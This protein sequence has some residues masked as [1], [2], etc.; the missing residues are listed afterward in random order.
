MSARRLRL[1]TLVALCV[2]FGGLSLWDTAAH[3][4]LAHNY[5]SKITE[6]PAKGPHGEAISLSGPLFET[7]GM[8]VDAGHL[9]TS[10]R[11]GAPS[12]SA[13][14]LDEWE[15]SSGAFV[16]QV[17]R[18]V[19]YG[20]GVAVD[21]S[22]GVV[23]QSNNASVNVL[24]ASGGV[25][26]TWHGAKTPKESFR[27]G[28]FGLAVD[29]SESLADWAKGDVYVG[30]EYTTGEFVVYVYKPEADGEEAAPVAQIPLA[31]QG[32]GSATVAVDESNGDVLVAA[33]AVVEIFKPTVFDEYEFVGQLTGGPGGPFQNVVSVTA[34]DGGIYVWE[35]RGKVVYQFNSEGAFLASLRG[36]PAGAF[37]AVQSV[38]VDPASGDLYVSDSNGAASHVDIF[39][40]GVVVPDVTTEPASSIGINGAVLNG[41]VNPDEAGPATCRFEWGTTAS[42]GNLAPCE[43]QGVAQGGSPVAV[44]AQLRGLRPGT[45]YY[46]RLQASNANGTNPG[47]AFQD[48]QLTTA[49][50]RIDQESASIVTSASATL[51]AR[52]DPNGALTTYYFQYGTSAA[53]SS[54]VPAA[55][56]SEVGSGD[57]D[58]AVSVHL[59]GLAVETT[60]HYR[61]IAV[62]DPNGEP[63]TVEGPDVTLTTQGLRT[64]ITQPD[65]RA[66]E[67][68]SPPN[69]QGADI[70][71]VGNEQGSDIQA[72]AAGGAMTYTAT[73]SI[74]ANPAGNRALETSQAFSARRAPGQWETAE[75]TTA[76]N[77]GAT[78]IAVGHS[79]E[80]KLFSSD[81]SLGLVEPVGDTPLPPLAAG[82]EKTLYLRTASGGYEALVTS[83]NVPAG[84][85][86]GGS[87]EVV[88]GVEFVSANPDFSDVVISSD[89]AL[90]EGDP[91]AGGLY[92]WAGGKLRFIGSGTLGDGGAE[93][94]G[95]VRHAISNDGSR[96]VMEEG[97]YFLVDMAREETVQ[98]DAA[99]GVAEPGSTTE[100]YRT[101]D[102]EGSRVF[103]TSSGRLTPSS[104][105]PEGQEGHGPED[106]YVFEVTSGSGEPLAGRLTDLTVP[107]NAGEA[108]GVSGVIGASEDGSYI[109]FAAGGALAPGAAAGGN[110]LY[111]D[112]YDAGAKAWT[113]TFV[114]SLSGGD[115]P[116]VG[117]GS[118]VT[119]LNRMTSRVSPSGRYLAFMSEGR[120]TG[121]E[122]SDANSGVPDEEVFLYDAGTSRLVCASCNPT[123]AR[124]TGIHEGNKYEENLFDYTKNWEGRWLAAN[125]PGWTS[126]SLSSARYQS[127]YLAD[128]GR[129]FF[130]SSDA[131]VPADVNGQEDVY[132]YEPAGVGGCRPPDYGQSAS[133]VYSEALGGCVALIS[134]GTSSE[135]SAFMDASESGGDVF[136]LTFSRL[137]PQDYDTSL[138]LYDA[139]EC[140]PSSPCAPT[141]PAVPAAC[142]TG[143]ACKPAPTTQ[144]TLFG[145]PSS[146]TFSGAGNVSPSATGAS[147]IPRRSTRAQKLA[148]ALKACR[149]KPAKKRAACRSQAEK[150]YGAKVSRARK[151]LS[152]GTR[153]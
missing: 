148:R 52:I 89:V 26:G 77:E 145:A 14:A 3:A 24:E 108:A 64:D 141:P 84:T 33:G 68:V 62:S 37:G 130:N 144:P 18:A 133:V 27:G 8:A 6:V 139:H 100:H 60:Y 1:S 92:E 65:G 127:R 15:A 143:D 94:Q 21:H 16:S 93:G 61:V 128:S 20:N 125:I 42:F 25:L 40:P 53:Y 31:V 74:V 35:S 110:N 114:A 117:S 96:I 104:T 44:Q 54:S 95:V 129:L 67:L 7:N 116:S 112:H 30:D 149:K 136:F 57:G 101:A 85:R 138:D 66:W 5:L 131:L 147:V 63:V 91:P 121:Y 58:V 72:A 71:A 45:T 86:F 47:E 153:R 23:Y 102:A 51:N 150:R 123:G 135:E 29:N 109:Y 70:I 146:E 81:L 134:A 105:A 73:A 46:Y 36:T 12:S 118:S 80:Y 107:A 55:P 120:L 19:G 78:E 13:F 59:Q 11:I 56:G 10:D 69:K 124:P 83:S 38:A 48:Q 98:I 142:T 90:V 28:V 97:H 34:G 115:G 132:E 82:S 119:N 22:T 111:V 103:F 151:S 106:L 17:S 9:F 39:G 140:T 87:G 75:I 49:G 50:P 88:G 2:L 152:V 32:A 113:P 122:N 4:A 79:S 41:T 43:P 126:Q 99:Q 76:H 137:A